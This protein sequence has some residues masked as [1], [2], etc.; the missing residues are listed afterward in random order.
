M[1]MMAGYINL[2]YLP[3]LKQC[4]RKGQISMT[5]DLVFMLLNLN[6]SPNLHSFSPCV[7]ENVSTVCEFIFMF[8]AEFV[9]IFFCLDFLFRFSSFIMY[10]G[11]RYT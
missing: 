8:I 3:Y 1:L 5:F 2:M 7:D 4:K 11:R 6:Q 10:I 9:R